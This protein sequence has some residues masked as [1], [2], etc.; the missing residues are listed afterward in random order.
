MTQ[1]DIDDYIHSGLR[2]NVII[3]DDDD[4]IEI[5]SDKPATTISTPTIDTRISFDVSTDKAV[6]DLVKEVL[7]TPVFHEKLSKKQH[8]I[9]KEL[10]IR[11]ENE[12]P[13]LAVETFDHLF[14]DFCID[15]GEISGEQKQ[16]LNLNPIKTRAEYF[17]IF[18][19]IMTK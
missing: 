15:T 18:S 5:V 19:I 17:F 8:N 10:D 7:R 3:N 9:I 14:N 13:F 16:H 1:Q 2:N 12:R 11:I 4:D 6:D